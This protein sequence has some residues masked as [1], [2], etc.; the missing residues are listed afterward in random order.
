M[1]CLADVLFIPHDS[2]VLYHKRK[3]SVRI[4]EEKSVAL[5]TDFPLFKLWSSRI[6]MYLSASM[7]QSA[8]VCM[9]SISQEGVCEALCADFVIL[10]NFC[11]CGE[12]SPEYTCTVLPHRP[13]QRKKKEKRASPIW[14]KD[15]HLPHLIRMVT[16]ASLFAIW[17]RD[18]VKTPDVKDSSV[19]CKASRRLHLSAKES[20]KALEV[21]L[22][23]VRQHWQ[24]WWP[25]SSISG[26]HH[27]LKSIV[28]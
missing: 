1:L 8:R 26:T 21:N 20:G 24:S 18:L 2:V 15:Y 22:N 25:S 11:G 12:F 5:I 14:F 4:N 16:T 10:T 23:L 6:C 9:T 27:Y 13:V 17:N 3:A 7:Q 28:W 19:G